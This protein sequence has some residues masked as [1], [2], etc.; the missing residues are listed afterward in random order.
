SEDAY[1]YAVQG[2]EYLRNEGKLNND[3]ILTIVDFSLPSSAKRLFVLDLKNN[4]VLY[5]TYVAHGRNSGKEYARQFSNKPESYKSSLGFYITQGTYIGQHGFS[6]KLEG[7]EEGIN[8]NA[9]SRAIVMHS[10]DY[11]NNKLIKKQGYI[12]RSLGCPALPKQLYRPIIQKIK[13]GSCL[14]MYSPYSN[15]ISQSKL[16]QQS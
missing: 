7:E 10:A 1:N 8:D 12:G 16:L 14:F 5:N 3:Q 13:D 11:V 15:Y 2:Y 6:L 4:K 9:L